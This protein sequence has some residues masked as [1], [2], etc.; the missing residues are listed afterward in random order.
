MIDLARQTYEI[1]WRPAGEGS[2]DLVM[3]M[4][5]TDRTALRRFAARIEAP[6]ILRIRDPEGREVVTS[7]DAVLNWPKDAPLPDPAG[8]W[9]FAPRDS[10]DGAHAVEMLEAFLAWTRSRGLI[11]GAASR[12]IS[13]SVQIELS[14]EAHGR[15]E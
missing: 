8:E 12:R 9:T 4:R 5:V 11:D 1:E 15:Q 6:R 3:S 14:G 10:G 7:P 13:R 2:D